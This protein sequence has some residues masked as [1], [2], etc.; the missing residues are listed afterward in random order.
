MPQARPLRS[1]RLRALI[2]R[3]LSDHFNYAP[4][5]PDQTRTEAPPLEEYLTDPDIDLWDA[6]N[7]LGITDLEELC[8]AAYLETTGD[9]E[10]LLD[11]FRRQVLAQ[12]WF[13]R[14]PSRVLLL[15]AGMSKL[16]GGPLMPELL[17]PNYLAR[18]TARPECLGEVRRLAVGFGTDRHPNVERAF[19]HVW[20]LAR[21]PLPGAGEVERIGGFTPAELAAELELHLSSVTGS[22]GQDLSPEAYRVYA[23][24]L[25][26]FPQ[27]NERVA[28][29]TFNYD[30]L[31]E[32]VLTRLGVRYTYVP[33]MLF[34]AAGRR[35]QRAS[36]GRDSEVPI[37]KV[38]GSCNWGICRECG[39][40]VFVYEQPYPVGRSLSTC[41]TCRTGLIRPFI[42]PPIE[43]KF[44]S[45][46]PLMKIWKDAI[47]RFREADSITF[48]GY[49]LPATD[50][51]VAQ[52]INVLQQSERLE[53]VEVVSGGDPEI[54]ERYQDAFGD[55]EW[56]PE[57]EYGDPN[58]PGIAE[59]YRL[60]EEPFMW[61][62][63]RLEEFAE[64]WFDAEDAWN[65]LPREKPAW[66]PE[67]PSDEDNY[68]DE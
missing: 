57:V 24:F 25:K 20:T 13:E 66:E 61:T 65:P 63:L 28:I 9:R 3:A 38:H 27:R 60:Y 30:L 36:P 67:T 29:V 64:A 52:F 15:G 5:F 22:I 50:P 26:C 12:G 55:L 11:R 40:G 51:E 43:N 2:E 19:T 10:E 17:E 39:A 32:R 14:Q 1:A 48:V 34:P 44:R 46:G 23:Q 37:L 35:H 42:I 58:L 18:S 45:M 47:N 49:S 33:A 21:A 31:A 16:A 41:P 8:E 4:D 53:A 59:T 54:R 56:N 7:D 68:I 6:F 62:G